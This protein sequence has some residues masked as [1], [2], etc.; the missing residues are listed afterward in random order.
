MSIFKDLY[1]INKESLTKTVQLLVKN[2][3]IV[4][5]GIIYSILSIIATTI[6]G[7]FMTNFVLRLFAR[8]V[9]YLGMSV[10]AS[11]YLYLMFK[12]VKHGKFSL[13]DFKNGFTV[14][15]RELWTVFFIIWVVSL[16]LGLIVT[17][18][19]LGS[20]VYLLGF[21]LLNALPETI[22]Q[23]HYSSPDNFTYAFNFIKEN[24][25]EWFLPNLAFFGIMFLTLRNMFTNI[26][27]F[28]FA[29]I[30]GLSSGEI[31][32]SILAL[33]ILSFAMIYRGILFEIL[34]TSTRRKRMFKR[35]MYK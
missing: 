6:A 22:Y 16:L 4:F 35:N 15:L 24:W 2:W 32:T 17:P 31:L 8:I 23:K 11:N 25:L 34:S 7:L 13:Q 5:T 3:P 29:F 30:T 9:L 28:S 27:S 12:I 21:I 20:I 26:F 19:G 10:I 33:A 1:Y 14:Y 18:F